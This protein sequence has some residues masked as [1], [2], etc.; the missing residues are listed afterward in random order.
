MLYGAGLFED[1]G[2]EGIQRKI[3]V[4]GDGPNNAGPPV[5]PTRDVV[6]ARGVTINEALEL[7]KRFV[8]GQATP[9]VNGVLDAVAN[10]HQ[11]EEPSG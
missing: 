5:A 9:F 8:G 4:S 7:T 6:V 1:N 2:Y 11:T 10:H 3:D